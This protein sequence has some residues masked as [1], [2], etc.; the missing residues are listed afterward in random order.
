MT[1]PASPVGQPPEQQSP[2]FICG[3]HRT[4]TTLLQRTLDRHADLE[5]LPETKLFAW[6]W[7][8]W[9]AVASVSGRAL[10]ERLHVEMP[11][12]NRAWAL[13]EQAERLRRLGASAGHAPDRF[14]SVAHVMEHVLRWSASTSSKHVGEKTPLH[15]YHLDAVFERF[16]DARVI[17]TERDLRGGYASQAARSGRD[18]SF[19]R[20]R[21]ANYVVSWVAAMRLADRAANRYGPDRVLR[22]RFESLV[23]QPEE[24]LRALCDGLGIAFDP[25]LLEAQVENSSFAEKKDPG[26]AGEAAERWRA[27]LSSEA[28]QF[29]ESAGAGPLAEHGYPISIGRRGS[30]RSAL[31]RAAVGGGAGLTARSPMTAC[32]VGRDPR[33]AAARR[34]SRRTPDG[35][36]AGETTPRVIVLGNH[37]SGTT[38]IASL[39]GEMCGVS[40]AID[41]PRQHRR[42]GYRL[43]RGSVSLRRIH[44]EHPELFHSTVLKIPALTFVASQLPEVFPRARYVAIIRDP[45][46][47]IRSILNRRGVSGDGQPEVRAKLRAAWLRTP[48]MDG[49]AW[50]ATG[51]DHVEALAHRWNAAVAAI[52]AL[53]APVHLV[54]Y[55]AFLADKAGVLAEIARGVGLEERTSVTDRLDH[56][57]QPAGDRAVGWERFFGAERLAAINQICADGIGRFGYPAGSP[58]EAS[59]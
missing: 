17:V 37:K 30:F 48:S 23:S 27:S 50:G 33:Y 43:A 44:A 34:V 1:S 22:A 13:P 52:D 11:I 39:L 7:R 24:T 31:V 5:I 2:I 47:N 32:Y 15:I 8:P 25:A 53:D 20:F 54:S 55:E 40:T 9:N 38:A 28:I 4:G 49:G 26:F 18:L 10:I 12:I 41:F 14:E 57:F 42:S 19:R 29:L 35:L 45:R 21:A 36:P 59:E 3:C 51:A 46:E 16:P 58:N 56:Q 6:L